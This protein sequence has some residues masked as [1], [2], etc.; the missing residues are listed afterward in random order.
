MHVC[1][2]VCSGVCGGSGS[3][4]D[5][6]VHAGA[7]HLPAPLCP[8]LLLLLLGVRGSSSRR[9]RWPEPWEGD[10]PERSGTPGERASGPFA[11]RQELELGGA[12]AVGA[13]LPVHPW[14]AAVEAHASWS[15][16]LPWTFPALF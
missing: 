5:P 6:T 9:R 15:C 3:L 14:L 8:G 12:R 1:V 7:L 13:L 10:L 11:P 16:F 4:G 2:D